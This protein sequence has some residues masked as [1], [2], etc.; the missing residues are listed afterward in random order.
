MAKQFTDEEFEALSAPHV[1]RAWFLYMDLPSGESRLH[2][3]I[4][5]Y[6]IGGDE[7]RGVSDPIGGRLVSLGSIEEPRFG[8]ASAIQVALSGADKEFIQSLHDYRGQVE[9]SRAELNFG[10]N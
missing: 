3:G 8:Q 10:C 9:G 7:W 4:G 5:R 6:Q 1:G 2:T